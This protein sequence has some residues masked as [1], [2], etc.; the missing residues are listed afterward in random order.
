[1]TVRRLSS[2]LTSAK[3]SLVLGSGSRPRMRP[4]T[5][6][7]SLLRPTRNSKTRSFSTIFRN[8]APVLR[9][10]PLIIAEHIYLLPQGF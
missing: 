6:S 7:N 2:L 9:T 10:A 4:L 5:S 1:M 8:K 3:T